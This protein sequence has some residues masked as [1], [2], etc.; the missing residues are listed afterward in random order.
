VV[1]CPAIVH[2]PRCM[3]VSA[4]RAVPRQAFGTQRT[5][6]AWTESRLKTKRHDHPSQELPAGSTV[7]FFLSSS[8]PCVSGKEGVVGTV[9]LVRSAPLGRR[10]SV[11]SCERWFSPVLQF[12]PAAVAWLCFLPN[13]NAA[14]Q[15]GSTRVSSSFHKV[16]A[17]L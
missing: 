9:H 17:V 1:F 13:P 11:R 4:F 3:N 6:H 10:H 2:R 5:V 8:L 16:K 15:R 14:L 12:L 7:P